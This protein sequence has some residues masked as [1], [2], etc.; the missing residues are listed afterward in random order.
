MKQAKSS[1]SIAPYTS[2]S[3]VQRVYFTQQAMNML[4]RP[5]L[6]SLLSATED[7]QYGSDAVLITLEYFTGDSIKDLEK[8][9]ISFMV[10]TKIKKTIPKRETIRKMINATK[11]CIFKW[12]Q[13]MNSTIKLSHKTCVLE[14]DL[15]FNRVALELELGNSFFIEMYF[16]TGGKIM[17]ISSVYSGNE[18]P[19]EFFKNGEQVLGNTNYFDNYISPDENNA[20]V[21]FVLGLYEGILLS[22][23]KQFRCL[24]ETATSEGKANEL[25][26]LWQFA[27][28]V[29]N[30]NHS[31][32]KEAD[33]LQQ[34]ELYKTTAINSQEDDLQDNLF[35]AF[36]QASKSPASKIVA[37]A[38][39]DEEIELLSL[40]SS[41]EN[42]D[43][44]NVQDEQEAL[45]LQKEINDL[46]DN[47]PDSKPEQCCE[48]QF[49]EEASKDVKAILDKLN[50]SPTSS[51]SDDDNDGGASRN[52]K[53]KSRKRSR[54]VELK[55][56]KKVTWGNNKVKHF[57]K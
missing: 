33:L 49:D 34:I 10:D 53:S 42:S 15:K 3:H 45:E 23:M 5:N 1:S 39:E 30:V 11:P 55:Q 37:T 28:L 20:L 17:N 12:A 46:S 38:N 57:Y 16:T 50:T 44:D 22:L 19:N 6:V 24:S 29:H 4:G 43:D 9:L 25:Y 26:E 31:S 36:V 32:E 8:K 35:N 18:E 52:Q 27:A 14:D 48:E 56:T 21:Q 13:Q 51:S 47:L 54:E 41:P 7:S 40:D 2:I